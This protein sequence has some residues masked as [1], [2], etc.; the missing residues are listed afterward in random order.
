MAKVPTTPLND[1][2]AMPV[3]GFG[4]WQVPEAD[5]LDRDG[6]IGPNPWTATF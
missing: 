6:R 3:L 5:A 2:R 4:V 1:G